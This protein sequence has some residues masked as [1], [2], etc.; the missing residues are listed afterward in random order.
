MEARRGLRLKPCSQWHLHEFEGDGQI[1]LRAHFEIETL[2]YNDYDVAIL[3]MSQPYRG[4]LANGDTILYLI[5]TIAAPAHVT[6]MMNLW[7]QKSSIFVWPAWSYPLKNLIGPS[8]DLATE[9]FHPKPSSHLLVDEFAI[10]QYL[11][12]LQQPHK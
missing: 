8:F 10:T 6:I 12:I 2:R 1:V 5:G 3:A 7:N 9:P 11:L 4:S